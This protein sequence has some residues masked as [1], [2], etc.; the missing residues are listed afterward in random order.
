MVVE[1]QLATKADIEK[2]DR[3]IED[4][5]HG[6]EKNMLELEVK[7][8]G[9]MNEFDKKLTGQMNALEQR[10][11]GHMN[12]RDQ[13]LTGQMNELERKLTA[14]GEEVRRQTDRMMRWLGGIVVVGIIE[15]V[16]EAALWKHLISNQ[17]QQKKIFLMR[18]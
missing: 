14:L 8:S 6:I 3:R 17:W 5:K 7:L 12:D 11:T 4:V 16:I 9:Q 2:L 1:D 15:C 10:L 13:K 18:I